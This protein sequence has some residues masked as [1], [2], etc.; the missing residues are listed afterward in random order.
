MFRSAKRSSLARAAIV[1][2]MI[3]WD[4][5]DC[6]LGRSLTCHKMICRSMICCCGA[7]TGRVLAWKR[8]VRTRRWARKATW[9]HVKATCIH[10]VKYQ[11]LR[12]SG[13]SQQSAWYVDQVDSNREER[14]M[15]FNDKASGNALL[16][17]NVFSAI[18]ES[19]KAHSPCE[20]PN[21]RQVITKITA[22]TTAEARNRQIDGQ[23]RWKV[24]ARCSYSIRREEINVS[25]W[26]PL[27]RIR[28]VEH[29]LKGHQRII[30]KDS[31]LVWK[32]GWN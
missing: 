18:V 26:S 28:D 4:L 5:L 14:S 21:Q 31:W 32:R 17:V 20:I 29:D 23:F 25:W 11:R 3:R 27:T 10:E 13:L 19:P 16:V 22:R 1:Y 15:V 6:S 9:Y 8:R 12:W 7:D 2:T 24:E 30:A